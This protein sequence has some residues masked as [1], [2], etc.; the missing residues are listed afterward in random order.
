[1]SNFNNIKEDWFGDNRIFN[2]ELSQHSEIIEIDTEEVVIKIS[3][4]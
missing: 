4:L 3:I 2:E 1:M